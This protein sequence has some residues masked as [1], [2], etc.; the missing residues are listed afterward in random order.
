M[1]LGHFVGAH[2]GIAEDENDGATVGT[3]VGNAEGLELGA[4]DGITNIL[5]SAND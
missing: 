4:T 5:P 3:E 1:S 2:D